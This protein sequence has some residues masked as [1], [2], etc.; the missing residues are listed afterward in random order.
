MKRRIC[1]SGHGGKRTRGC[2]DATLFALLEMQQENICKAKK[3]EMTKQNKNLCDKLIY[4]K[5][6]HT[7]PACI[8]V[9][10]L[11]DWRE[12]A[13]VSGAS[14]SQAL[15]LR[16]VLLV[17]LFDFMLRF[18]FVL[19][20]ILLLCLLLGVLEILEILEMLEMLEVLEVLVKLRDL[21]GCER[22]AC[23]SSDWCGLDI[24]FCL[25]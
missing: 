20:G 21:E 15:R 22:A 10:L 14:I 13:S 2:T 16:D 7:F 1:C 3:K 8:A 25:G 17:V 11:A 6:M 12:S 9:S 5:K 18:E 24:L 4:I 19:G 23:G